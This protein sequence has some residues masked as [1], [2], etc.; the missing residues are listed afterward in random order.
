MASIWLVIFIVLV[1]VEL[2]TINLV[3]IWFAIAAV[4]ALLVDII[5]GNTMLEIIVFTVSS[6]LLLLLTKP[7]IKKLKVKKIE[8]TNLDMVINK[9]GIVTEDILDD[10]IGEVK[11]LGKKWSAYSDTKVLKG[12]RVKILSIDGVR[13]K[14]EKMGE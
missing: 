9:V 10:K 11:V 13:L 12:E 3:T 14:V 8:A 6:F 2:L 5:T 4:F 7:L 1:I